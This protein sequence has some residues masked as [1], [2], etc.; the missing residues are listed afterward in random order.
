MTAL[1]LV[2]GF[3]GA[4]KTTFLREFLG[5]FDGLRTAVLVNE[6]GKTGVDGALLEESRPF[7]LREVDNGSIF[8]ACRLEQFAD[9]LEELCTLAPD[10]ILIEASGLSDPA[11]LPEV[12]GR[13]NF[14][15]LEYRGCI[16]LADAVRLP[17]VLSTARPARRQLRAA[18]LVLLNQCDRASEEQK[19]EARR[20]IAEVCP[21][22][23]VFETSF[24]KIRPEW[25]E[26]FRFPARTPIEPELL[27]RDVSLCKY[28]I[29]LR[30]GMPRTDLEH[31]LRMFLEETYRVKGFVRLREGTFL[32]DCV[33]DRLQLEEAKGPPADLCGRLT[34]L[35][36]GD[37]AVGKALKEARRWYPDFVESIEQ[38]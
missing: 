4:G 19:Q 29:R 32:A 30:E 20:R 7:A 35:S 26:E 13:E 27:T 38:G 15:G 36:G 1:Y 37:L 33:G 10:I 12:L 6:F 22:V 11:G 2:T 21:G 23:P 18:D 17:G 25:A 5:L 24:G 31:F 14:S 16:C 3:L 8:C 28:E 9:A 34:V